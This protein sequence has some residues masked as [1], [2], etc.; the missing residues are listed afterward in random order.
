MEA[1]Q[2]RVKHFDEENQ[3]LEVPLKLPEKKGEDKDAIQEKDF[4]F[5][6][7]K[8]ISTTP[9]P[10]PLGMFYR[11]ASRDANANLQDVLVAI[12]KAKETTEKFRKDILQNLVGLGLIAGPPK[13][14]DVGDPPVHYDYCELQ[15]GPNQ[16]GGVVYFYRENVPGEGTYQ[17]AIVF[18]SAQPGSA[19][20]GSAMDLALASLRVDNAARI[21]HSRFRPPPQQPATRGRR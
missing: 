9:E 1:E 17:V 19:N 16:P 3:N 8:G 15:S 10:K 14:R 11:Y 12:V 7:P 4:F 20:E 13:T 6:P 21:Q 5:R 2:K 18:R